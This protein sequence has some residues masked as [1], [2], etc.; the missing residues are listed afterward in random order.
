MACRSQTGTF[1]AHD[2]SQTQ[3]MVY[4]VHIIIKTLM[5]DLP[6]VRTWTHTL[7]VWSIYQ[8]MK[9]GTN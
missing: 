2:E 7:S 9:K 5:L 3:S 8:V 1:W 6:Y 4:L